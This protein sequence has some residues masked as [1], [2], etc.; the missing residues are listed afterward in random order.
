MD[1]PRATEKISQWTDQFEISVGVQKAVF[2]LQISIDDIS[3]VNK[4]QAFQHASNEESG[5]EVVEVSPISQ[6]R[7]QFPAQANIHNHVHKFSITI[8]LV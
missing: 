1:S 5:R 2:R 3:R 4:L 6:R 7:P 8:R